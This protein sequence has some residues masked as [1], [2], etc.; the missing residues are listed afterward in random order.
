MIG[1][2]ETTGCLHNDS[3]RRLDKIWMK[4]GDLSSGVEILSLLQRI[5]INK[6]P[7]N[8]MKKEE[9]PQAEITEGELEMFGFLYEELKPKSKLTITEMTEQ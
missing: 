5:I 4:S 2:L 7:L 9:E 6:G 3:H 1:L 8:S